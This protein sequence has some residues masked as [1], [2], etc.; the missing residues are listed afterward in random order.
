MSLLRIFAENRPEAPLA[1]YTEAADI[2]RELAAIGVRFEQW[3]ASV[4]LAADAGQEAVLAAY[5]D[6]VERLNR[7]Y[8]FQSVDVVSLRPDH[9]QKDEF[10]AKFL[11]EHTH[12]DFEVRFFVDGQGMFYLH[13]DGKVYAML[14]T[15]GDLISVPAGVTHWFDM[16]ERPSFKCIRF[17]TTPEGWVGHFTGSG[18]DQTFPKLEAM[19]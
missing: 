2:A 13:A 9:P 6:D 5:R 15:Q 18:I 7:E 3:E 4:P 17:F 14:C 10:R 19:P 1:I 16:G 11:A 12:D 8:G